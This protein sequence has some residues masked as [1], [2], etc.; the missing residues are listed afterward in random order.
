MGGGQPGAGPSTG[1][2]SQC[3]HILGETVVIKDI[4]GGERSAV[5]A[6]LEETEGV[7]RGTFKVQGVQG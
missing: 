2:R 3:G 1:A 5:S 4:S 7:T 6:D